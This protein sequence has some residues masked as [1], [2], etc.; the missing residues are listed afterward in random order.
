MGLDSKDGPYRT[1][2]EIMAAYGIKSRTTIDKKIKE[3]ER[4]CQQGR[5]PKS[6][7]INNG[8]I[9]IREYVFADFMRYERMFT[10]APK[11]VPEYDPF[12]ISA[13]YAKKQKQLCDS[14]IKEMVRTVV[15]DELEKVFSR[16]VK[17]G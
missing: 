8:R 15:Q 11:H 4:L 13:E 3:L 17:A 16:L 9:R 2:K 7:V 5:Y 10:D 14:E 1:P 12:Q 6:A